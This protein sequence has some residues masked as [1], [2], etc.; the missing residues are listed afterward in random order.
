MRAFSAVPTLHGISKSCS[1]SEKG[2]FR[3]APSRRALK[4]RWA[5]S[6]HW[7][8]QPETTS[9]SPRAQ[10][11][12]KETKRW[13]VY[14]HTR[15]VSFLFFLSFREISWSWVFP[16]NYVQRITRLRLDFSMILIFVKEF[17]VFPMG[18]STPT[19][20]SSTLKA[21]DPQLS[22]L[23]LHRPI[24]PSAKRRFSSV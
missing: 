10:L 5:D 7:H 2:P 21:V 6:S 1:G 19:S 18:L 17:A 16:Q 14:D 22:H 3:G 8:R 11:G 4:S 13:V 12:R 20:D 23:I 9:C 15:C 24:G